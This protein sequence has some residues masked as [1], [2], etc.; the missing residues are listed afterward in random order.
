MMNLRLVV[1]ASTL[2][3]RYKSLDAGRTALWDSDAAIAKAMD[4]T[5]FQRLPQR[6]PG[7]AFEHAQ[8]RLQYI[9]GV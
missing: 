8:R 7:Q 4:L 9:V 2:Q 5:A 3:K 1:R 6:R